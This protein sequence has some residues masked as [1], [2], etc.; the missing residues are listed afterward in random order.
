MKKLLFSFALLAALVG[1]SDS[2]DGPV[3]PQGGNTDEIP[4]ASFTIEATPGISLAW[5]NGTAVSVFRSKT[6]EK[7]VYS[8]ETSVFKKEDNL[9][10]SDALGNV[11]GIHPYKGA[12]RIEGEGKVKLSFPADQA[13]VAGGI[14]LANTPL[15]AVSANG[16]STE[17]EFKQVAGIACVK[18]YGTAAIKSVEVKGANGESLAGTAEATCGADSEPNL[19]VVALKS[20]KV[21][22]TAAEAVTLGT[23]AEEATPFYVLIPPTTFSQGYQITIVDSYDNIIR[24]N[25]RVDEETPAVTVGRN[26]IVE[27]A[28]LEIVEKL[29]LQT[30]LDIKFNT[31]GSAT[32]AGKYQMPVTTYKTADG[33]TPSLR[34]YTHPKYTE[35]NIAQFSFMA[36]NDAR[37]HSFYLVDYSQ[38]EEF[39]QTL[40]DGFTFEVV[41]T[42][43]VDTW[44]W[45]TSPAASN[46]FRFYKK[47][48]NHGQPWF[49]HFNGNNWMPWGGGSDIM[50]QSVCNLRQYQHSLFI[51]DADNQCVR[52]YTNGILD[53]E[54]LDVTEFK[55]GNFLTVGGYPNTADEGATFSGSIGMAFNGDVALVKI[56]DQPL[57]A[58]EAVAKYSATKLPDVPVTVSEGVTINQPLLD[59]KWGN[60]RNATNAGTAQV[61]IESK[62]NDLVKVINVPEVGNIAYFAIKPNDGHWASSDLTVISNSRYHDGFYSIKFGDNA[63][64]VSKLQDGFTMEFVCVSDY[65]QGDYWMRPF[66]TEHWGLGLRSTST[67]YCYWLNY[68]NAEAYSWGNWGDGEQAGFPYYS[69]SVTK[70]ESFTHFLYVWDAKTKEFG[71]FIDGDKCNTARPLGQFKVGT[72]LNVPGCPADDGGMNHGWNG[73]VA[74]VRIY[75]EAFTQE[76][77]IKAYNDMKPVIEKLNTIIE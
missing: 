38:Q 70:I 34:V 30:I 26:Q 76:Q 57:T 47:C 64:F 37:N 31:D 40:Q 50:T 27:L 41:S 55:V 8:A 20:D 36:Y 53:S 19:S 17:M 29:P 46:R 48:A 6:N 23:T 74:T 1:C 44:D 49:V 51:Y 42:H 4:A 18:L 9:E 69:D 65:C 43:V 54:T 12:N 63:D 73:K 59:L 21:T 11:Y 7:F 39:L 28:T 35:N 14:S 2:E 33:E 66:A 52:S 32:D 13:Y 22:L 61:T 67:T 56:Y 75:D 15:V 60:D 68:A 58:E 45:W 3:T 62:L 71:L 10:K 72:L 77:R 16:T 24:K 5:E 25:F